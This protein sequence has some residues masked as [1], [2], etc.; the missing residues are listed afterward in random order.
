MLQLYGNAV[1]FKDRHLLEPHEYL[2]LASGPPI[3]AHRTSPRSKKTQLLDSIELEDKSKLSGQHPKNPNLD[4]AASARAT[5]LLSKESKGR[6]PKSSSPASPGANTDVLPPPSLTG[7][8]AVLANDASSIHRHDTRSPALTGKRAVA[9]VEISPPTDV[10]KLSVDE[11]L[12][13]LEQQD[14]K[15]LTVAH[16]TVEEEEHFVRR[17][18]SLRKELQNLIAS[19]KLVAA[20][21]LTVP[22]RSSRQLIVLMTPNGSTRPHVSGRAKRA[23]SRIFIKL[24]DFDRS[25]LSAASGQTELPVREL[26]VRSS[27]VRSVLEVQQSSINFGS[28][29]KGETK[30]KTI[31][32]QVS[33]VTHPSRWFGLRRP[34]QI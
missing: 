21:T 33:K 31:V 28:C 8:V 18:M 4:F 2:D 1:I 30:S 10:S 9:K 29:E 23:D 12:V 3:A 27:C 32:I 24:A 22:P 5:G 25:I 17:N 26:I 7:M 20:P 19:G 15:K 16:S 13:A 14:A 6:K 11:L 34:E